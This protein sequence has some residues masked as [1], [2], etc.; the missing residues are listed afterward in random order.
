M[1]PGGIIVAEDPGSSGFR[2]KSD[3]SWEYN[4]QAVDQGGNN[5]PASNPNSPYCVT[6]TL[7]ENGASI[8]EQSGE[9]LLRP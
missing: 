6:V 5:L 7:I 2:I 1:C 8:G 9:V 4:W 3:L